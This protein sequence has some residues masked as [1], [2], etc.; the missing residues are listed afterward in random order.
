MVKAVNG[1]RLNKRREK[2]TS[3]IRVVHE[4]GSAL[5]PA[6]VGDDGCRP[7]ARLCPC[8]SLIRRHALIDQLSNFAV[9]VKRELVVEVPLDPSGG[10][11]GADAQLQVVES[12]WCRL[13][14]L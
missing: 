11:Q 3:R 10:E 7:E 1:A 2:R 6:F 8:A 14:T 4:C 9:D 12:H 5:V 13:S